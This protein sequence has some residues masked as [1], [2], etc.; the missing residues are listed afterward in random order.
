MDSQLR[1]FTAISLL[2]SKLPH[3]WMFSCISY[4]FLQ[5]VWNSDYPQSCG[6]YPPSSWRWCYGTVCFANKQCLCCTSPSTHSQEDMHP[7]KY[8]STSISGLY[9]VALLLRPENHMGVRKHWTFVWASY[10]PARPR[11]VS[12]PSAPHRQQ[13]LGWEEHA[14]SPT[15]CWHSGS[16]GDERKGA[17]RTR[18][19]SKN[20]GQINPCQERSRTA[21]RS[22]CS[23]QPYGH[24]STLKTA[25]SKEHTSGSIP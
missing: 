12:V 8:C 15:S 11:M 9:F 6:S 21:W 18:D 3:Q 4:E 24:Q 2:Y 19:R 5:V 17:S 13:A 10:S 23:L 25:T 1:W 16:Q 20:V 14:G 7:A 22:L